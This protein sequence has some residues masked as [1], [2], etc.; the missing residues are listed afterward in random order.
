MG[1]GRGCQDVLP[2][3][4]RSKQDGEVLTKLALYTSPSEPDSRREK[5]IQVLLPLVES[6]HLV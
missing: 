5:E 3:R 6:D 1:K 2:P 4:R